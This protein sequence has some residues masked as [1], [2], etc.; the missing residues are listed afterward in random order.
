MFVPALGS[1]SK[2]SIIFRTWAQCYKTFYGH[3]LIEHQRGASLGQA[4]ALLTNV[5]VRQER[6]AT[7][8]RSTCKN[9]SRKKFYNIDIRAQCYKT[10]YGRNI[11]MLTISQCVCYRQ[12]FLAIL[13][14]N[15]LIQE[16]LARDKPSSLSCKLKDYNIKKF[17]NIDTR[18]Q[19]YKTF[20][21]RNLSM[22]VLAQSVCTCQAFLAQSNVFM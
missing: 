8:K 1:S 21:G 15:G 9:Q 7:E 4:S 22:F 6:L 2:S 20:Y 5:R 17:Y 14:N 3:N 19:C 18:A 12:A 16:R 11:S 13:A 10:F